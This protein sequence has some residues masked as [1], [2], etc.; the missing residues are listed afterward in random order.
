[1][2]ISLVSLLAA[3]PQAPDQ[4]VTLSLGPLP[5]V[6][7]NKVTDIGRLKHLA[8]G[9][10]WEFSPNTDT[11]A[12]LRRIGVHTLRCINVDAIPGTFSEEGNFVMDG[13][14]RK[15]DAH[16]T[17]CLELGAKPHV[18]IAAAVP[19]ALRIPVEEARERLGVMGQ[20]PGKHAYWTGDWGKMRTYWKA[21]FHHVMVE[22]G[23]K[24]A[25]FEVGNEPDI[26]GQFPRLVGREGAMGSA[27]LYQ[28][29]FEVYQ[30]VVLAAEEFE[31]EHPEHR[32]T[33]G[34]PA[35]SWAYS[36]KFGE[37]NWLN[38]FLADCAKFSLK[39]DFIGVHYYGNISSVSGE[40]EA[41][42]PSIKEMLAHSRKARDQYYPGAPFIITEWGPS[43][44]TGKR[45]EALIN[46]GA[47]AAAW[48]AGFLKF[49]LESD[50]EE[51]LFLVTTD[52]QRINQGTGKYE[53]G[54]EWPSL[55]VNPQIFG[56]AWPKP[57]FH[58]L[59]MISW[60]KETRLDLIGVEKGVDGIASIDQTNTTAGLLIWNFSA[61]I[62]E[63]A[64]AIILG[65]DTTIT[66]RLDYLRTLQG[67]TASSFKV[68]TWMVSGT[69]SNAHALFEKEGQLNERSELQLTDERIISNE[70]AEY[71]FLLPHAAVAYV[72]LIRE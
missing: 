52:L 58:L 30:N 32:V 16:L 7:S 45:P 25:R 40:Y 26:D 60:L 27:A 21:I 28:L 1:M 71:V 19:P 4:A 5:V 38:R 11:T 54:W 61:K 12:A 70:T 35:L 59:E 44:H 3:Q 33:I 23:F 18:I 43:Y 64:P 48:S 72:E 37:F 66:L 39:L 69:I 15:L 13:P 17:T 34:G 41:F 36:F 22:R 57:M 14:P 6:Q 29:Y 68:K 31:R 63:K 53:N 42:Y 24:N 2:S 51:A 20:N 8:M 67:A 9:V 65:H 10:G 47:E 62:P 49:L 56:K 55:F 50:V 46:A